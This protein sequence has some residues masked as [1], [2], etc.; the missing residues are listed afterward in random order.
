MILPVRG[1]VEASAQ[2]RGRARGRGAHKWV[3]LVRQEDERVVLHPLPQAM[4]QRL[5][6]TWSNSCV[7]EHGPSRQ[8]GL[9]SCAVGWYLWPPQSRDRGASGRPHIFMN[10]QSQRSA[11]R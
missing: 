2:A 7:W 11:S 1:S 3:G 4:L 9:D 5:G 10:Q 6:V 8:Q